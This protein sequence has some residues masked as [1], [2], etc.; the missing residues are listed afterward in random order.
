MFFPYN[1]DAP[2][3]HWPY[4]TVLLIAA[5]TVV[6]IGQFS[7]DVDTQAWMLRYDGGLHPA[8]WLT[9]HLVH[10][11]PLHLIGNMFFLWPFG[12]VVEGKVGWWKFLLIYFGIGIVQSACEQAVMLPLATSVE[13]S[14]GAS[15]I[16]FGLVGIAWV[17]APRNEVS[18]VL[19]F[20]FRAVEFEISIL[21][22][23]AMMLAWQL[24]IVIFGNAAGSELLHLSGAAIGVAVGLAMLKLGWVDC[25]GYDVLS[26]F[27]DKEGRTDIDL[28]SD[29]A[30][31]L[32][33]EPTAFQQEAAR[34]MFRRYVRTGSPEAALKLR[35][36]LEEQGQPLA[37]DRHE[38][39]ALVA[40][41]HKKR[42][43]RASAPVMAEY[44]DRFEQNADRVRLKL[45]QICVLEL[46]RPQRALELLKGLDPTT[47]TQEDRKLYQKLV[48]RS[49][50]MQAEGTLELDDGQ[51]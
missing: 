8:Q 20:F 12:I 22:Y 10:M 4:A 44:L 30:D 38:L 25:E 33:E 50:Q 36:K 47:L 23:G 34:A 49:K 1:T 27:R 15:A 42:L 13:G 3:Y 29:E 46:D 2:V 43:W 7:G 41:L 11:G 9:S 19:L 35:R 24:F 26:V 51:W 48:A 18:C 17:W 28:A 37:L 32:A 6:L 21:V 31:E 14:L 16:I 45:A 39:A 40:A 5:N